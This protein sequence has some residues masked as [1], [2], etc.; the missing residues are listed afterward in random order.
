VP[1]SRKWENVRRLFSRRRS[2]AGS[3]DPLALV[4]ARVKEEEDLQD[5]EEEKQVVA[6]VGACVP[7]EEDLQDLKE[8]DPVVDQ[9][10]RNGATEGSRIPSDQAGMEEYHSRSIPEANLEH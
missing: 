9:I 1:L 3:T 5:L 4:V 8:G 10:D 2:S 7:E 6:A